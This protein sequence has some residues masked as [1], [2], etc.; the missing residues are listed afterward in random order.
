VTLLG[1][2]VFNPVTMEVYHRDGKDVP[3]WFLC[4]DYNDS[5]FHIS[6]AFFPRTAAIRPSTSRTWKGW[7]SS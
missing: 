4:A 5:C 7:P 3:A 6:Q 1:L 2:D